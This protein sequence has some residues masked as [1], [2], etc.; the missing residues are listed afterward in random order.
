[1]ALRCRASQ[2]SVTPCTR[3]SFSDAASFPATASPARQHASCPTWGAE[4]AARHKEGKQTHRRTSWLTSYFCRLN[5]SC[6]SNFSASRS[7]I[8]CQSSLA[9][10]LWEELAGVSAENGWGSQ[11]G[12]CRGQGSDATRCPRMGLC[13][14]CA[15]P[16]VHWP[17]PGGDGTHGWEVEIHGTCMSHACEHGSL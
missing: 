7:R 8:V 6:R 12:H 4:G 14:L 3:G 17:V 13:R 5:F 9:F 10:S 1:M 2:V 11:G 15:H 16:G